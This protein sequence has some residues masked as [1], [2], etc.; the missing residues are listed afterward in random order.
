M[1]ERI[2]EHCLSGVGFC[3]TAL[4]KACRS[5]R[6]FCLFSRGLHWLTHLTALRRGCL[7]LSRTMEGN[8]V[9]CQV[10][11]VTGNRHLVAIPRD[12]LPLRLQ[13]FL[14][15]AHSDQMRA[16]QQATGS[17]H[18]AITVL[19]ADV[20]IQF[21][22]ADIAPLGTVVSVHG[23]L[24]CLRTVEEVLLAVHTMLA[25][26]FA[27]EVIAVGAI[28]LVEARINQGQ[29]P[30]LVLAEIAGAV[31]CTVGVGLATAFAS[32]QCRQVVLIVPVCH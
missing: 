32:R 8:L 12:S 19:L 27:A 17:Q 28:A 16:C 2:V 15:V 9:T 13:V 31:D 3:G 24:L 7:V 4:A 18:R 11:H 14:Q 25:R 29:F 22:V 30:H 20:S 21:L 1:L 5:L 26:P 23:R 6:L 10:L